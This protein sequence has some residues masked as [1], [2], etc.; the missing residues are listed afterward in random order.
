MFKWCLLT[1]NWLV[2]IIDCSMNPIKGTK[3]LYFYKQ[4]SLFK[5]V[6][7]VFGQFPFVYPPLGTPEAGMVGSNCCFQL[8]N[9][10]HIC[11]VLFWYL[12]ESTYSESFKINGYKQKK[13]SAIT[14]W[15]LLRPKNNGYYYIRFKTSLANPILWIPHIG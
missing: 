13:P 7:F 2:L 14:G 15:G 4:W 10:K 12:H 1:L 6:D 8:F 3:S 11:G 9:I 5:T